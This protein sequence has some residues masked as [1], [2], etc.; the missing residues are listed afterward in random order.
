MP[1]DTS[2]DQALRMEGY[3]E[4]GQDLISDRTGAEAFRERDWWPFRT[5]RS[6]GN[7]GRRGGGGSCRDNVALLNR[8]AS[9]GLIGFSN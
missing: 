6:G 7:W 2:I 4:T 1:Q 8:H 9:E 3:R 5:K